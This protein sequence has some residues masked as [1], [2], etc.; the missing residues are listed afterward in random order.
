MLHLA[1]MRVNGLHHSGG[2]VAELAAANEELTEFSPLIR[3]DL[4]FLRF[5]EGGIGEVMLLEESDTHFVVP[6]NF[7][8][9]W[10]HQWKL[11]PETL[12]FKTFAGYN[13]EP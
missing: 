5:E 10:A 3:Q 4:N 6:V 2:F 8:Y 11:T 9:A 13:N 7:V 1:Q 12:P